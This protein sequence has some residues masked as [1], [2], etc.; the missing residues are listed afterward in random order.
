MIREIVEAQPVSEADFEI[1]GRGR[2]TPPR[3]QAPQL[4]RFEVHDDFSLILAAHQNCRIVG[5][6]IVDIHTSENMRIVKAKSG[7]R[8]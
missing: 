3:A 1:D 7:V 5:S 8:A 2:I 6:S 4:T